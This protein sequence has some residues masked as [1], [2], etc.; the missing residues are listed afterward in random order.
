VG[1]GGSAGTAGAGAAGTTGGAAGTGVGGAAGTG[2]AAGEGGLGGAAGEA[3]GAGS[4]G[5][6]GEAGGG[7]GGAFGTA[8]A[9]GAGT[10]GRGGAGAGGGCGACPPC[11]RCADGACGVDPASLWKVSCVSATIAPTKPNGDP[12]DPALA[13]TAAPDPQCSFWLGNSMA[14]QTSVLANTLMPIWNESITPSS[15]FT[16]G[17]LSSQSS[18]WSIRVTDD[19]PPAGAETICS[20]SPALDAEAFASGSRSFAQVGSCAMLTIGLECVSQ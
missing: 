20:V 11:M 13:G 10:G 19:D 6:A 5:A 2:A 4:G 12:W 9:G 1:A 18:P 3:G 16:A 14:S 17:L 8:G 7:G 15:R